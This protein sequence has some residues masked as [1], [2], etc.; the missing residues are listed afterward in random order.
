MCWKQIDDANMFVMKTQKQK[1]WQN[2]KCDKTQKLK[3]LPNSKTQNVLKLKKI[4]C[5]R[6]KKSNCEKLT[7]T[8]TQIVTVRKNSNSDKNQIL[9]TLKRF[10][11]EKF[12]KKSN[13]D[14]T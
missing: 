3:L 11:F 7:T 1:F 9:Q 14:K 2:W 12:T 4:I 6:T 13:F 5:D 10:N 8:K